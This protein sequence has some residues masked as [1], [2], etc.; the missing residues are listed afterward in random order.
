MGV[1]HAG[2]ELAEMASLLLMGSFLFNNTTLTV[3]LT[4]D[5]CIS[6]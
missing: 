2:S 5:D 1:S 3:S 4:T 6:V